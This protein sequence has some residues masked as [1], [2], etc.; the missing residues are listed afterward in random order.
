MILASAFLN[1]V[2][3]GSLAV[4]PIYLLYGEEPL[5]LRDSL[6][7]LKKQLFSLGYMTSESY[8]VDA[9]FDWQS[10]QMDT[11]A[12]SLFSESRMILINMP[13]GSPGRDGGKFFQDWCAYVQ[14]LPPEIV[15]VVLCERLDSRQVKAK[16]VTAIESAG[17]VVQA[18]PVPT[19]ALP[20]WCQ[21]QAQKQGLSLEPE[22]ANLLADRVEGNLLAADQEITKLSLSLPA[23]S[24]ITAQD[25]LE[26]VVDQAHYQLFALATAML[27]GNTAYSVQMLARLQQE[28]IEA[29]VI[30]WLLSKELRQLIELS[31]LTQQ[32][33][34]NQAFQ[35]CRIWQS[36]QGEYSSAMQRQGLQQWQALLKQALQIDMMIKGIK[37]TLN[38][39]EVWFGLADLVAKIAR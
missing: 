9:N 33:S 19:N 7:G 4:K 8:D 23:G 6:D 27:N 28:G 21:T 32:I 18:K 37:P 17:L 1:Q 12:G 10:L 25:I 24:V 35:K 20:G 14:A 29:P 39:R 38:E 36:R 11:Q 15:L 34:L 3:S 2:N 31:Q 16:W 13:K 22:A 5:F 30:L 26:H